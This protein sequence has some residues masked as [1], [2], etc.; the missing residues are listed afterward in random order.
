MKEPYHYTRHASA[1]QDLHLSGVESNIRCRFKSH[2]YFVCHSDS[3]LY[4]LANGTFKLHVTTSI[5]TSVQLRSGIP[6]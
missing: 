1:V 6:F 2:S 4:G 3:S 5:A